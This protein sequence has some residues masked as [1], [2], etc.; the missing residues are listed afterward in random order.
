ME[1]TLERANQLMEEN[2]GSLDL[3]GTNVTSLPEGLTVNG[4]LD[5][6]DTGVAELPEG[7]TVGTWLR[8]SGTGITELPKGLSVGKLLDLSGTGITEL[9][10]GLTIA[11]GLDLSG[12]GV[13]QLPKG[14]SVGGSL[15]LRGTKIK[16]LPADLVVGGQL[17]LSHTPL[18]SLPEDLTVGSSLDLRYSRI[19]S[20]PKGLVVGGPLYLR[21]TDIASLPVDLAVGG[22][23]YPNR[24]DI[25]KKG[26]R[27]LRDGDYVPGRYLYADGILT[28]VK[29][30][31]R[32]DGY[33][34]YVGRIKGRNVVSD[35]KHYAHCS[36][37]R[38]GVADLAFKA[39]SDRGA[40][41]YKDLPLDTEMAVGEAKTMYRVITGACRQGTDMFVA[42]LKDKLKDRYTIR[43]MLEITAGQYGHEAFA[44]FFSA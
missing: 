14:L 41:Q 13:N 34:V 30:E 39:A 32:L 20:L 17:D 38:D 15:Y 1:L 16:S 37:I 5:L 7:L 23:I 33:T 43:E 11:G 28:P 42:G 12:T 2:R 19:K 18:A 22:R 35:G 29:A 3:N 36:K 31:K 8:L 40:G 25:D 9:P 24:A 21:G 4:W 6:S 10:E 27:K 26:V 44:A